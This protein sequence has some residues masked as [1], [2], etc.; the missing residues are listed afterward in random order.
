[1]IR[2]RNKGLTFDVH[3][4]SDYFFLLCLF[5]TF[6]CQGGGNEDIDRNE[7]GSIDEK[8]Q[9]EFESTGQTKKFCIILQGKEPTTPFTVQIR[10]LPADS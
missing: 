5:V 7:D 6:V 3:Y 10:P 4:D 8:A 1:M 2:H 9:R